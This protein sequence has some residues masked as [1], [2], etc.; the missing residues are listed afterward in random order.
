[1]MNLQ[2]RGPSQAKRDEYIE[3]KWES[4]GNF[5]MSMKEC[6]AMEIKQLIVLDRV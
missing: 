6:E 4:E 1:M 2:I 5:V 3:E